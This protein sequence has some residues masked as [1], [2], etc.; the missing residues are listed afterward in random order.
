MV[1]ALGR[2]SVAHLMVEN[3]EAML[4][5][6]L[7]V[8]TTTACIIA[9][10]S[11]VALLRSS[12]GWVVLLHVMLM[13]MILFMVLLVL[14]VV[15]IA[16]SCLCFLY[17]LCGSPHES[18]RAVGLDELLLFMQSIGLLSQSSLEKRTTCTLTASEPLMATLVFLI[19][20]G[21]AVVL[22]RVRRHWH[23]LVVV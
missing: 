23:D 20:T 3:H 15:Q 19:W 13:V 22:D 7:V 11:L 8:N 14:M 16:Y 10:A 1:Y 21:T 9:R 12:S 4:D 18:C 2:P 5:S 17:L 6:V